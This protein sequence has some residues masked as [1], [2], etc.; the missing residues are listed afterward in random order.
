MGNNTLVISKK[1]FISTFIIL[2]VLTII[3]GILTQ[4]IPQGK[5]ERTI[6]EEGEKIIA[7]SFKFIKEKPLPIYHWFLAWIEVLFDKGNILIISIILFIL[8]IGICF[9]IINYTGILE[10][11]IKIL[12]YKFYKNKFL[13]L[14][15]ITL[16]FMILG[17]MF[18]IFEEMLP[19]IPLILLLSKNFGWDQLTGLYM[20]L[21][22]TGCGFAAA[23]SNPFTLGVAQKLAN[24]PV[25]S[26]AGYR[27]FIFIFIYF[28]LITFIEIYIKKITKNSIVEKGS[29]YSTNYIENFN[30]S[31]MENKDIEIINKKKKSITFFIIMII[32]MFCFIITTLFINNIASFSIPIIALIFIIIAIGTS[33][34]ER[35]SAKEIIKIGMKGLSG[36]SPAIILILLA[37]GINYIIKKG[38]IIDTIL[39]YSSNELKKSGPYITSL[40]IYLITLFLNFFI[41][42]A[43]AK[44]FLLMPILTPLSDITGISRQIIVLAFQF[45]DGFSN[46]I[47]P[48]NPVLIIG[49]AISGVSYLKWFKA[50]ILLQIIIFILT[51]IFL[52]IAVSFGYK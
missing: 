40:G 10:I 17:S 50:T 11:I 43:S 18:G 2:L 26:G 52:L 3:S 47:Y 4:I 23:I 30:I 37:M 45:G 27:I 14:S 16:F 12:S 35:V 8:I 5:Y 31:T 49:L 25:L 39:F 28:I 21:L 48:T 20:S 33:I 24:I 9:S 36:I 19:L 15:I 51:S 34:I 29:N 46:V 1:A 6:S 44:A 41:G 32:I 22:A 7:D 13:L 42:S 38:N